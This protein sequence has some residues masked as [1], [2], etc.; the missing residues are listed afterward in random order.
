MQPAGG[1]AQGLNKMP[2]GIEGFDE[3]T[4]GGLPRGRTTLVL[5][6]AGTGKTVFALQ[7]LVNSARLYG[8]PGIFVAIEE[9]SR[10]IIQNA[11][12]FGWDLPALERDKLFFL[13]A[14]MSPDTVRAGDFDL[15]GMLASL[16]AKAREMGA[17]RIVFD[18][19][20]I[21]LT[22]LD[23]T[24]AERQEVYRLHD[25]L[26]RTGLTGI[27]TSGTQGDDPLM[28]QHY[29]FMQFMADCVVILHHRLLDRVSLRELR[30]VKYRGSR[31]LENEYP[32]IIANRGIELA[33]LGAPPDAIKA[34][35]ERVSTG[36]ERLDTM[37][38]GGYFRGSS[39]LITGAPGTAKSTL[40]A[41]F[42][43][44]ACKRGERA[45]YISYDEAA[46]EIM[47]NMASVGIDLA[48][49]VESGLLQ[50]ISRRSESQSAEE[51][52][53][54]IKGLI[55]D[56]HPACMAI[57][58]LSAMLKAG[59]MLSA[60]GVVQRL[61]YWTKAQGITLVTTSLLEGGDAE[62][63]AT[64]LRV[65]TVADTWIHLT[66]VVAAGE[67]NRA[68]TIVKARGTAHS[69]QVRELV[70]SNHGITLTDVYTSGGEVLMGTLRWEREQAVAAERERQAL[71]HE[72]KQREFEQTRSDLQKRIADLQRELAAQ[73]AEHEADL[74]TL[75]GLENQY[76]E[77]Q[78]K[79]R[80]RRQA[81]TSTDAAAGG[82]R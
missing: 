23:N 61:L 9:N 22:L 39:T 5:G 21:L 68:L 65:S 71:E 72:R 29:G 42:L 27:I 12:S 56:H 20:D 62:L 32:L 74:D 69:N 50:I 49:H 6:S 80:R 41:A 45:L 48:P 73:E 53:I 70:L 36:V 57:D 19:L 31:F 78:V 7:T 10:Q 26:A 33:T 30:V 8:E 35:A 15:T 28:A 67:R 25:W 76:Q 82:N 47:R 60:L 44:A 43:D 24:T 16:E 58:P 17:Q 46:S 81:D 75:G 13:D 59:G 2:T 14:R 38:L 54:D 77:D 11:A 37:L 18:S 51:H 63:E 4:G 3:I 52:L 34:S 66:Y 79:L 1:Q 64:E 40:A 55:R